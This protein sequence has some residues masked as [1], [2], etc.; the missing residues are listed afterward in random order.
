MPNRLLLM[1][2]VGTLGC[3]GGDDGPGPAVDAAVVPTTLTVMG[4][5]SE[6]GIGGRTPL[7]GVT[8]GAYEEAGAT[9]VATTTT[10]ADGTYVLTIT[11]DGSALDGYVKGSQ[12]GKKDNYLYP[13]GPLVADISGAT[14]LMLTQSTFDLAATL[15]QTNQVD[16]MGWIGVQVYTTNNLPVPGV[17]VT[18]SPAGVVRYNSA[19]GLPSPDPIVTGT[20]GI[21]YIFNVAPGQVTVS[22]SGGGLTFASHAV[23]ARADQ[24]TTTLIQP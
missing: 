15:A 2:L 20:D 23:N 7:A 1:V 3:G 13:A 19:N 9:A 17:T 12:A 5:A 8:I 16:G 14:I 6:I 21:A 22:A 4:S 10:G 11:T 18:S 24:V